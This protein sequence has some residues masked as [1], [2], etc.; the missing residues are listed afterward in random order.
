MLR[1]CVARSRV[2][3][4]A[5]GRYACSC[6]FCLCSKSMRPSNVLKARAREDCARLDGCVGA[7]ARFQKS[8]FNV[9]TIQELMARAR[10]K[11]GQQLS[12]V[13]NL[14]KTGFLEPCTICPF[15]S[16]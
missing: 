13:E 15:L 12:V 10:G 3:L 5:H 4:Y 16:I 14:K 7:C 11:L 8:F 1:A 6:G 9:L 2:L